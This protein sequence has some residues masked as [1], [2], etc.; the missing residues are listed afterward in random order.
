MCVWL[1]LRWRGVYIRETLTE[2]GKTAQAAVV[3][4][5]GMWE[6]W[7]LILRTMHAIFIYVLKVL[8]G[9]DRGYMRTLGETPNC[10]KINVS[11]MKLPVYKFLLR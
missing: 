11:E 6:P 5:F 7:A 1:D 4:I 8:K 3:G 9:L 2:S 10:E